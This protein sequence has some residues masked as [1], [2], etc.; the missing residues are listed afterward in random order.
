VWGDTVNLASRMESTGVPGLIQVTGEVERR[1]HGRFRLESRGE[2][3]IK[4]KGP[5][6][7][8]FL[9]GRA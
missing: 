4:G 2:I 7:T 5:M 3:D 9:V 8:F 1:L 6:E